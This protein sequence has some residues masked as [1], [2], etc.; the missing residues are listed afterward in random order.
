MSAGALGIAPY[1]PE[2]CRGRSA[3]YN[4][5]YFTVKTNAHATSPI[6]SSL[7]ISLELSLLR[8]KMF[9]VAVDTRIHP[10]DTPAKILVVEVEPLFAI[11][12]ESSLS[13]FEY[14]VLGPVENPQATIYL[15]TTEHIDAAIVDT[16]IDRQIVEAAA[17][18]LMERG[19]RFVY[20]NSRARMFNLYYSAIPRQQKYFTIDDLQRIITRLSSSRSLLRNIPNYGQLSAA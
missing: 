5:D 20:I 1:L 2:H 10:Q 19:I 16:N 15:A 14:H 3:V 9:D 4:F 11:M 8:L 12:L 6:S 13:D 18:R 17:D 7:S